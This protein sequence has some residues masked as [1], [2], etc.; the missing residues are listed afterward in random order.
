MHLGQAADFLAHVLNRPAPSVRMVSRILREGGWIKKGARGRNA[1]HLSADEL[2]CFLVALMCAPDSP[3]LS[4]ERLPHFMALPHE[5]GQAT[6]GRAVA[7]LLDR[8]ARD[9]LQDS[10][11]RNWAAT[12]DIHHSAAMIGESPPEDAEDRIQHHFGAILAAP[13]DKPLRDALPYAGGLEVSVTAHWLTL[14]RIAKA[15]LGNEADPINEI[16]A[17]MFPDE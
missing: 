6:F 13:D 8:L 4:A 7:M 1:P 3:A 9:S 11:A 12:I 15:V 16:A 17:M 10:C 2:A 5:E 14:V